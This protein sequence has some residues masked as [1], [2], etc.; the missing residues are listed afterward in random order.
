M[1]RCNHSTN[2]VSWGDGVL[3]QQFFV[4][5]I[6]ASYRAR[7]IWDSKTLLLFWVRLKPLYYKIEPTYDGTTIDGSFS[8]AISFVYWNSHLLF[9]FTNN[10]IDWF[11]DFN[12]CYQY[13]HATF[14]Y[15]NSQY[16]PEFCRVWINVG[17]QLP[18][19][20]S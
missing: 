18:N 13:Y 4:V 1:V 7:L 10:D 20:S 14:K 9:K 6:D 3:Q 16:E 8:K 12:C 19:R 15:E 11:L 2:G 5:R 17:N